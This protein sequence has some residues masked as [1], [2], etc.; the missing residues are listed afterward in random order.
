MKIVA[1][2]STGTHRGFSL[3]EL[4][5]TLAILA[6]LASIALPSYSEYITRSRLIDAHTR[7]GDLRIQMEKY[8]QD[9]RTYL[10][11]AACG[12]TA[13]QLASY[14]GDPGRSFDFSCPGPTAATYTLVATGRAA[15]GMTGFTFSVDQAG[16]KASSGP[17]GW[18]AAPNCWL[19]RKDGSCS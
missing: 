1:R 18:T 11:G 16:N 12:V 10:A 13:G 9:N 14:N 5:V 8:F 4:M 3:I 2:S 15:K 6:I 7:L 19:V 17:A